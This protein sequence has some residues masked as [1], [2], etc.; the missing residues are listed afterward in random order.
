MRNKR[1][2]R[3]PFV[4]TGVFMVIGLCLAAA[5]A[6]LFAS[7][8]AQNLSARLSDPGAGLFLLGSDHFGRD[9]LARIVW[10]ARI[11]LRVG[12]IASSISL[13][14]GVLLGTIAG[15][16]G[17]KID[18]LIMRLTDVMMGFPPLLFL[19]AI[20]AAF[21]PGINTAM[22]AIGLVSW[23]S[24]ARLTRGQVMTIMSREY[25][26]AGTAMGYSHIRLMANHVLP[27][28]IAP[29]LVAF[30][31]GISGAIMAEASLSFLGLGVQPP[32]ASWGVMI[33]EGKDFLRVAPWISIFPGIA[34]ALAVLGFNL[35]GEGLRDAL[36][37]RS[38][39]K[40][41]NQ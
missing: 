19:I 23:P 1:W 25:V 36:D 16:F 15:Y 24:M 12:I 10:G 38:E 8:T 20:A 34:I 27:N 14:I 37:V 11:S 22:L 9:L 7:P 21:E 13:V 3:E 18:S 29:L 28:C 33:N 17:G 4:I 31:L 2:I 30:S 5:L 32:D 39:L 41:K 6:P 26:L 40:I 35:L